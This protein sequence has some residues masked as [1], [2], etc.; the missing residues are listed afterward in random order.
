[1]YLTKGLTWSA[2]YV[3]VFDEPR[4]A[5][6]LQG[7]ITLRNTSGTTFA[8]ARTQLVAGDV[9]L[10]GAEEQWWQVWQQR[11]NAGN[12]RSAGTE[13]GGRPRLGDYYVYPIAQ[14]TTV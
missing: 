6:A 14:P 1:T 8:N 12:Q 13:S 4:S 11:R 3:M 9:N 10:V 2:D 5:A 7:W